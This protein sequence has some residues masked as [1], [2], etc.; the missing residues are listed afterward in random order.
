MTKAQLLVLAEELGVTGLSD[1]TLKA[2]MI[3]TI[4]AYLEVDNNG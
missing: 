4:L 3:S 1:K 2:D